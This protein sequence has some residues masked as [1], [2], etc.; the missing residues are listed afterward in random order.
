M[1]T[2]KEQPRRRSLNDRLD[3]E[4]ANAESIPVAGI[5]NEQQQPS[6]SEQNQ[7]PETIQPEQGRVEPS[8]AATEANPT[9]NATAKASP[10]FPTK[11]ATTI[12]PKEV[13]AALQR[14]CIDTE[15]PKHRALYLFIIDG[16]HAKHVINDDDYQRFRDMASQLTTTYEKK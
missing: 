7:Q 14:Y 13:F 4:L 10:D 6:I 1:A 12:M 3:A 16:L 8:T 2:K 5:T 15:T 9:Q 11:K